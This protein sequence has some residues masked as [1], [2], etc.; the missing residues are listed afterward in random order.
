MEVGNCVGVWAMAMRS[1][2]AVFATLS[3][4]SDSMEPHL[5]AV[6][7]TI[8]PSVSVA[9]EVDL[10]PSA[11]WER[12]RS[13]QSVTFAGLPRAAGYPHS[14]TVLTNTAFVIGYDETTGNAAWAAYRLSGLR[15]SGSWPRPKRFFPDL[16]TVS[17]VGHSDY[18]ATGYDRG[19][20][21]PSFAIASR[22]GAAAQRET[23]AM[24]NAVPQ[25]PALNRGP[26]RVL[27]ETLTAHATE[28]CET[29]WIVVGPVYGGADR[30]LVPGVRIPDAFYCIVAEEVAGNPRFHTVVL[31]QDAPRNARFR[32]YL[33][34][35]DAVQVATGLDFFH[36]LP[37][38]MERQLESAK[39]GAW[40]E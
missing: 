33:T 20:L 9:P 5:S 2:L 23:F 32:D 14:I 3:A 16:R 4:R 28:A 17:R 29:L 22:F 34:T 25:S 31:S 24:T 27:E 7:S 13:D 18:T 10:L 15:L 11:T 37:D 40:L 36:E 38:P 8:Q 6:S 30:R 1:L 35:V 26:W 39:P 21:V 19:H 12:G